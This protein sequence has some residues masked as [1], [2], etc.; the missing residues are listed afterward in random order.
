[1][2]FHV[3]QKFTSQ[4]LNEFKRIWALNLIEEPID[5]SDLYVVLALSGSIAKVQCG[6]EFDA[7]LS[8][9]QPEQKFLR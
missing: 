1:M 6:Q 3:A 8:L 2:N 9:C 4:L 7:E 5:V